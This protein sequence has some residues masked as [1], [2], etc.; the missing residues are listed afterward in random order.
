MSKQGKPGKIPVAPAPSTSS[1]LPWIVGGIVVAC[2]ALIAAIALTAGDDT[3]TVVDDEGNT[4]E[5]GWDA[6]TQSE[7]EKLVVFGEP[8]VE[9]EL[10]KFTATE[11]DP[12]IGQAAPTVTNGV[13]IQGEPVDLTAGT[14]RLYVFAAHWCPHCQREIPLITSWASD[15]LIPDGAELVIVTTGSGSDQPNFPPTKWLI[16]EGWTGDTLADSEGSDVAAAFGLDGYP[17]FVY[18]NAE[19]K[20][21]RRASGGQPR[22]TIEAGFTQMMSATPSPS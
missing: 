17:Y 18:V 5:T 10:P 7:R 12:A 21:T 20:V 4:V 6:L 9:G 15:G 2:I 19:G 3:Q 11:G 16:D 1:K 22:E 13:S 8:K 14:P